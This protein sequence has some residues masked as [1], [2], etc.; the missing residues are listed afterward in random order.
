[1]NPPELKHALSSGLFLLPPADLD[2]AVS[3]KVTAI[4]THWI[5]QDSWR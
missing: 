1:M 4:D 5:W 3:G 2:A